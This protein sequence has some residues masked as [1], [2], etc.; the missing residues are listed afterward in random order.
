MLKFGITIAALALSLRPV[1][2]GIYCTGPVA[3]TKAVGGQ[4]LNVSWADDGTAPFLKDIGATAIDIYTGSVNQ[5]VWLQQLA[6]SVDVSRTASI[7]TTIDPKIGPDGAVYFVRFTSLNLADTSNP[8]YKYEAFSAQF[9]ITN[10]QGTF[11][12]TV[13]AEISAGAA[14]GLPSATASLSKSSSSSSKSSAPSSSKSSTTTSGSITNALPLS[15]LVLLLLPLLAI[16][17]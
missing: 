14:S 8:K 6:A 7:T 4:T 1:L 16:L 12:S 13:L 17:F 2:A 11:N 15:P 10:M 9:E 5:Q 3:S